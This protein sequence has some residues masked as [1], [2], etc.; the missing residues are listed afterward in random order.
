VSARTSGS[1]GMRPV[2][3]WALGWFRGPPANPGRRLEQAA[4]VTLLLE[5]LRDEESVAA[6]GERYERGSHWAVRVA[7]EGFPRT[8]PTLGLHACTACAY[9]F[10]Y[11]ELVTGAPL[12][13]ASPPAWLGEWSG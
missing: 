1:E 2:W 9:A 8:W 12:R 4:L 7:R 10:R 13:P 11:V 6:L 3:S 5:S